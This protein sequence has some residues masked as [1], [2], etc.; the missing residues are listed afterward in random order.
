MHC[1][2]WR[3]LLKPKQFLL[4]FRN[5]WDPQIVKPQTSIVIVL[6]TNDKSNYVSANQTND[7]QINSSFKRVWRIDKRQK[8]WVLQIILTIETILVWKRLL[9]RNLN[10]EKET[11]ILSN[12]RRYPKNVEALYERSPTYDKQFQFFFISDGKQSEAFAKMWGNVHAQ[13]YRLL[14]TT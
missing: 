3:Y 7:Y 1:S 13:C 14:N 10:Y 9:Q 8:N 6:Y 5:L 12:W 2:S 11:W 4:V